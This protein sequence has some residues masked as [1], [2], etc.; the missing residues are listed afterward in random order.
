[1]VTFELTLAFGFWLESGD[2][3][4]I[5]LGFCQH[6]I[7]VIPENCFELPNFCTAKVITDPVKKLGVGGFFNASS[8]VLLTYSEQCF[9][10]EWM[11]LAPCIRICLRLAC[12][13]K[14]FTFEPEKCFT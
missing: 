7:T 2:N 10:S 9:V 1:V 14:A 3:F 12:Q 6:L 5:R 4:H 11:A 8:K 13:D